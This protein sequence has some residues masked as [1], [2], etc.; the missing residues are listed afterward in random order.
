M[1]QAVFPSPGQ[2]IVVPTDREAGPGGGP[3]AS[4]NRT[5][6][7]GA[8]A[9]NNTTASDVIMLGNNAGAGGLV[10]ANATGSVLIG[11]QVYKSAT[12]MSGTNPGPSV[13]I[14]FAVAAATPG[15]MGQSVLIGSQVF[16]NG[17]PQAGD[18]F[19]QNVAIGYQAA[20]NVSNAIGH[21]S[22]QS[23]IIGALAAKCTNASGAGQVLSSVIVGQG[24]A[25]GFTGLG[26]ISNCVIIGRNAVLNPTNVTGDIS[27]GQASGA[28]LSTGNRNIFI[29]TSAG[30]SINTGS[31]NVLIG[32]SA[33]GGLAG[34]DAS[35]YFELYGQSLKLVSGWFTQG[36][37]MVGNNSTANA[38]QQVTIN[39]TN[40]LYVTNGTRGA[41][42]PTGGG[43]FY[44]SA[45]ALHYVGSAGTDTTV[46]PA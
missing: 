27:I 34:V 37:L 44:V 5:I 42:N 28:N 41:G 29:G 3:G 30:G 2:I 19:T 39:G 12:D 38:Q 4:G 26:A 33:G 20:Q 25:S 43:F 36:C 46:A 6:F 31:D 7:L 15:L 10:D 9:G 23:V 18:N 14:G 1:G 21:P 35:G 45:G 16:Q 32:A 8:N 40:Q 22:G 11:S 17:L 24:A 13:M